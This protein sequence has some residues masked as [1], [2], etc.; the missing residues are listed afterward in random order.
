[1]TLQA[2]QHFSANGAWTLHHYKEWFQAMKK[3]H[4]KM[5]EYHFNG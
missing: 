1:M 4:Q 5:I 2:M 3:A